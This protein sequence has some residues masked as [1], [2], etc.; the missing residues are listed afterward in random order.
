M[1]KFLDML[2]HR[3]LDV[4]SL[5]EGAA[6]I[7]IDMPEMGAQ[8]FMKMVNPSTGEIHVEA[9]SNAVTTVEEGWKDR[10]PTRLVD[11]YGFRRPEAKA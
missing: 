9:V 10:W 11:K 2:P 8:K 3:I 5:E 1:D 7:E 4:D 6:L